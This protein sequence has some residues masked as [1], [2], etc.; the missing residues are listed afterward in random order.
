MSQTFLQ[1]IR[2][3]TFF[4]AIGLSASACGPEEGF[5]NGQPS[6]SL[7]SVEQNAITY[8]AYRSGVSTFGSAFCLDV[9][10]GVVADS[11]KVQLYRCNNTPAQKWSYDPATLEM[12]SALDPN[13]CLDLAGG[14]VGDNYNVQIYRCNGTAAQK[15][16]RTSANEFRT[17]VDTS[18]CLNVTGAVAAN[19]TPVQIFKCNS[20]A[21]QK[22]TAI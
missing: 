20:S 15:W 18:Y 12:R 1:S 22:W 10:G 4:V 11:T 7:E 16:N 3:L 19:G 14:V 13:F 9:T 8:K 2:S 5:D 21:A 17:A 6:E